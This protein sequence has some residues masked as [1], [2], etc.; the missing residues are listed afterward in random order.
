MMILSYSITV[1]KGKPTTLGSIKGRPSIK[2]LSI[3]KGAK[4]YQNPATTIIHI[5]TFA[6]YRC[7]AK[8]ICIGVVDEG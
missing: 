1:R 7:F 5:A 2:V 8:K 4:T 6:N 3:S